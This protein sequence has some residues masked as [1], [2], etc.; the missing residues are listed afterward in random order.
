MYKL[1]SSN[2]RSASCIQCLQIYAQ[3]G[4]IYC[5]PKYEYS[6]ELPK[7]IEIPTRYLKVD[8]F[9]KMDP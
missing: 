1:A 9:S 2:I 3:P 6:L 5:T 4:A 8:L 7:R